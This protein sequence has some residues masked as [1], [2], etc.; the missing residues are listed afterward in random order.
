MGETGK[1][2]KNWKTLKREKNQFPSQFSEEGT[3][4]LEKRNKLNSLINNPS[5][6]KSLLTSISVDEINLKGKRTVVLRR[7]ETELLAS[8][9]RS[10]RKSKFIFG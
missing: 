1:S 7:P 2:L 4:P 10:D 6:C 3:Q 8:R 5:I 9:R